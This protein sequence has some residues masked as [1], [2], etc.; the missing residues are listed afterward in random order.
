[1]EGTCYGYYLDLDDCSI[2]SQSGYALFSG[3][4]WLGLV[5][6]DEHLSLIHQWRK[7]MEYQYYNSK[8]CN[9]NE[10]DLEGQ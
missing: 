7:N 8:Y 5:D 10:R 2:T 1:M 3:S 4:W 6:W 9:D